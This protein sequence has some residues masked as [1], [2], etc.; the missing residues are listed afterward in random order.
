MM[1]L[2]VMVLK[3]SFVLFIVLAAGRLL[4]RSSS[5]V[6]HWLYAL[7][8]ACALLV[9]VLTM[10]APAWHVPS[11][12]I[13]ERA[14]SQGEVSVS[15]RVTAGEAVAA[16][17]RPNAVPPAQSVGMGAVLAAVW[18]AGT[19]LALG[20]LLTGLWRLAAVAAASQRE[21]DGTCRDLVG[22]IARASGVRRSI[23]V[24]YGEHPALLA[25]WGVIKP[26][27][28]LP[29]EARSWT[30]ERLRPLLCHEVAH[31]QRCDWG[32]H[33]AAEVV[34]AVYWF[35]PLVWIACRRL[36]QE[37]EH[38]C[39]DAVLNAG[40]AA[41]AYASHLL[42]VA[43]LY[44]NS[45]AVWSP[46][47][48]VARP[49]GLERRVR[50]MLNANLH[51]HPLTRGTRVV[52]IVALFTVAVGVAG[53]ALLAQGP[54]ATVAGTMTDPLR[55]TLIGTTLSI[56][57]AATQARNEVRTD[58]AGRFEFVGLPP[59][60]Y[61][62]E[63][64]VPGFK[65]HRVPLALNGQQVDRDIVMDVG[66]LQEVITVSD[67]PPRVR[68]QAERDELERVN[69]LNSRRLRRVSAACRGAAASVA[70][71][72]SSAAGGQIRP[73]MKI[74]DVRP[75]YPATLKEAKVGGSVALEARI[76]TDGS[77]R[78]IRST[79]S[80]SHPDLVAAAT[81]AVQ[82]WRFDET[83]LN[84]VPIEVSMAVQVTFTPRP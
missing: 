58:D 5:A 78:E 64:S 59:G 79:D 60:D 26:T 45:R 53:V 23:R 27:I 63:A 18:I 42:D 61:V 44:S 52:T 39:D 31:I 48:A 21:D 37:S 30:P 12:G 69:E 40:V 24:L 62:L 36:R 72:R 15:T 75:E 20:V 38:A 34:R 32:A 4:R 54:F 3:V 47:L 71:A 51:R 22:E 82:G 6:R 16:A 83:L 50:A 81:K 25:T 41:P 9:P 35:N 28:I 68:S 65:A 8:L 77:V 74:L 46:A 66:A 67:A 14:T 43:R 10:V 73:P 2:L 80:A 55:G 49:S 56:T 57:N 7:G 17:S 76:G 11:V 33:L 84:C 19:M 1:L 70:D 13:D 29:E